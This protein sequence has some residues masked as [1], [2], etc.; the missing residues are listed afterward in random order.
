MAI[1]VRDTL[2]MV[3]KSSG[4]EQLMIMVL[5]VHSNCYYTPVLCL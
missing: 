5:R 1:K 2:E 3:V 4:A